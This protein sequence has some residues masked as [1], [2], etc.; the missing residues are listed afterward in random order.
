MKP[1]PLN[2]ALMQPHAEFA[3]L[4]IGRFLRGNRALPVCKP[5]FAP[6]ADAHFAMMSEASQA[7][8]ESPT[9]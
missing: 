5:G 3:A 9:L 2:L 8:F 6:G 7:R 4:G 1:N